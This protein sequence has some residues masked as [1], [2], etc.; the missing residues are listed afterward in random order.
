MTRDGDI[1]LID[2]ED[3]FQQCGRPAGICDFIR[4]KIANSD[5]NLGNY[6]SI[7]TIDTDSYDINGSKPLTAESFLFHFIPV[8]VTEQNIIID[9]MESD[10][11]M[12]DDIMIDREKTQGII[13]QLQRE[14]T[15]L[16]K[17]NDKFLNNPSLI[18]NVPCIMIFYAGH[19]FV[20][21]YTVVPSFVTS[22][23]QKYSA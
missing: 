7:M 2:R 11:R 3:I 20:N 14:K 8:E 5:F 12:I 15:K 4:E 6:E 22:L 13:R 19:Q 16:E 23:L 10:L 9:K 18:L 1:S 17:I 21:V